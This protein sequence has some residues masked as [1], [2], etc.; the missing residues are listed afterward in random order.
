[1]E[2]LKSA[3]IVSSPVKLN[4]DRG[5]RVK[6]LAGSLVSLVYL[7]LCA[8]AAYF[9]ASKYLDTQCP[10]IA[11]FQEASAGVKLNL[12]DQR[13][14]P[15]FV[16]S[17]EN[18]LLD[19]PNLNSRYTISGY[20]TN[21]LEENGVPK[22]LQYHL[23][24]VSCGV[25][26]HE[27]GY[28]KEVAMSKSA[29]SVVRQNAICFDVRN[30][31]LNNELT[32]SSELSSTFTVVV[33]S[34]LDK[35][36]PARDSALSKL[37]FRIGIGSIRTTVQPNDL[38][39]A[40]RFDYSM[41]YQDF[42][43]SSTRFISK[44]LAPKII[45]NEGVSCSDCPS[46]KSTEVVE[47][48]N[49]LSL[50]NFTNKR[51]LSWSLQASQVQIR[52]V[53]TYPSFLY[54]VGLLGGTFYLLMAAVNLVMW[55]VPTNKSKLAEEIFRLKEDQTMHEALAVDD[56]GMKRLR[57]ITM[58]RQVFNC[59]MCRRKVQ[60]SDILERKLIA[61]E[62]LIEENLNIRTLIKKLNMVTMLQQIVLRQHDDV[63]IPV[64]VL[65]MH[66]KELVDANNTQKEN[67]EIAIKR[68]E[69]IDKIELLD[70]EI[71]GIKKD[72]GSFGYGKNLDSKY[73]P[74][75]R[76]EEEDD[77]DDGGW[78][79]EQ[80]QEAAQQ[81]EEPLMSPL[82]QKKLDPVAG[83]GKPAIKLKQVLPVANMQPKN[84]PAPDRNKRVQI[85]SKFVSPGVVR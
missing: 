19:F 25:I 78:G 8:Y 50:D 43:N 84:L 47:S 10:Q 18:S 15:F 37:D 4:I 13:L 52:L 77:E 34:K 83:G 79:D 12:V 75:D 40:T 85:A 32:F 6:T 1:M 46:S 26:W 3:D 66:Q 17:E 80:G 44:A 42:L 72:H 29:E 62:D 20:L 68:R 41:D 11:A 69:R 53:R 38:R 59:C 76:D 73:P 49:Y 23:S 63:L 24:S 67:I 21:V 48:A 27:T 54:T 55:L 51:L 35:V 56:L 36:I 9:F 39:N 71:G 33:S 82:P 64:S 16:F 7:G 14:V 31:S 5:S 2:Y 70:G 30:Q 74:Q 45:V 22:T 28:F 57:S 58:S 60:G 61:A 81:R 65:A